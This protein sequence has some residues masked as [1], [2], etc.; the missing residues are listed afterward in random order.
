MLLLQSHGVECKVC[1]SHAGGLRWQNLFLVIT[2]LKDRSKAV[3]N[4]LKLARVR[5]PVGLSPSQ[6]LV[7]LSSS[8]DCG[9][10]TQKCL[11]NVAE[12][13]KANHPKPNEVPCYMILTTKLFTILNRI[14]EGTAHVTPNISTA[15]ANCFS[16]LR[17][18]RYLQ[19]P[20]FQ[21]TQCPSAH[22]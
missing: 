21:S 13:T 8:Q 17:I 3:F 4:L 2:L 10:S 20:M 1:L 12:N 16:P 15:A 19:F 11:E 22:Q 5:R 6:C 9:N 7:L 18:L 14:P